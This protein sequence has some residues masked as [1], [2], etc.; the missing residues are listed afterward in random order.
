MML[1]LGGCLIFPAMALVIRVIGER[2][3]VSRTIIAG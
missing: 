2:A 3:P 1:V